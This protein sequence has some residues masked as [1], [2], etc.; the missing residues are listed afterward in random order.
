MIAENLLENWDT[1]LLIQ[2]TNLPT[3]TTN[4]S[5]GITFRT[6]WNR[7]CAV[8]VKLKF[9]TFIIYN[10]IKEAHILVSDQVYFGP[11]QGS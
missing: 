8:T 1:V 10:E 6:G 2:V 3:I 9:M 7:N 11:F 4:K 5:C